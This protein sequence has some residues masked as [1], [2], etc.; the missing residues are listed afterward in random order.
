MAMSETNGNLDHRILGELRLGDLRRTCATE[1][2]PAGAPDDELAS[3]LG[4]SDRKVLSVYSRPE[5]EKA[6]LRVMTARW[7]MRSAG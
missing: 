7:K 3:V 6:A 2:E 4:H 1:L 5:Y